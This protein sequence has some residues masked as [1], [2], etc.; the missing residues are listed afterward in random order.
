MLPLVI[1][2]L[3]TLRLKQNGMICVHFMENEI[4][5]VMFMKYQR[6][7][8]TIKLDGK[9]IKYMHLIAMVVL[10]QYMPW[11]IVEGSMVQM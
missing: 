5:L 11:M 3:I 10:Q 7:I 6:H 4:G 1:C 9:L 8:E 2:T